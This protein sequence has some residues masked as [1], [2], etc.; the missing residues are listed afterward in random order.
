MIGNEPQGAVHR[1]YPADLAK[2]KGPPILAVLSIWDVYIKFLTISSPY[3]E[4]K[5]D[6]PI[7]GL[8]RLMPG[9]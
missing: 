1:S 9:Y 5:P 8:P 4:A 2:K 3:P 6:R 7:H